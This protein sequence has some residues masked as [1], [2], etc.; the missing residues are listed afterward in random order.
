MEDSFDEWARNHPSTLLIALSIL[1]WYLVQLTSVLAF[2]FDRND[3]LF[4]FFAT[5]NPSP[6]WVFAPFSHQFP[7]NLGHLVFNLGGL[8]FFGSYIESH[9]NSL[10]F[11][12]LTL[13][14]GYITLFLQFPYS[15]FLSNQP[16]SNAGF[17][18]AVFGLMA[19]YCFHILRQHEHEIKP[20][21][22]T[23]RLQKH[24]ALVKGSLVTVGLLFALGLVSL[25]AL[26]FL[27]SGK[28]SVATHLSGFFI[29]MLYEYLRPSIRKYPCVQSR[30]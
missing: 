22:A 2:G 3:V 13:L 21:N 20:K 27:S 7:P 17:S 23:S 18:G 19:F 8:L 30:S 29:G 26:Q 14:T 28:S 15:N 4:W 9:L 11:G 1:L 24:W 25:Q 5:S 10:E 16:I 6:A 12:L